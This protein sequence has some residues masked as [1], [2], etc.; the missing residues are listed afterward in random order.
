ML[1][2]PLSHLPRTHR[3]AEPRAS[4]RTL[5]L[6]VEGVCFMT[7]S[8]SLSRSSHSAGQPQCG[9][10]NGKAGSAGLTPQ[11]WPGRILFFPS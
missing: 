11:G 3:S 4:R 5:T 9:D 7:C 2:P 1:G 6:L 10:R 8:W